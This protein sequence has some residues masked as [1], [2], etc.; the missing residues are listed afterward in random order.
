MMTERSC[1]FFFCCIYMY[2]QQQAS[3]TQVRESANQQ[4]Y[5]RVLPSRPLQPYLDPRPA[6]SKYALMPIVEQHTPATVPLIQCPVFSPHRT[7]AP[8][9]GQAPWSGY[10]AAIDTETELRGTTYAL[11]WNDAACWV[12][13]STSDL[14]QVKWS[15]PTDPMTT[16]SD[17]FR[18]PVP[19]PAHTPQ[20]FAHQHAFNNNTRYITRHMGGGNT[21]C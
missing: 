5:Q 6:M 1:K 13:S 12:P 18:N 4:I 20:T 14:F 2:M 3:C 16:S 15:R 17:L 9:V 11:Q 8:C 19:K 7:F 21:Q 10:A